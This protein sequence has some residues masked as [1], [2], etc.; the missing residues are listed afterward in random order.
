MLFRSRREITAS[1]GL[2]DQVGIMVT[3]TDRGGAVTYH[4][5][6]QLVAYPILHLDQHG[7]DIH[8]LL[9]KYEEVVMAVLSRYGIPGERIK[10]YPGVWV[11]NKKICALGIGI[12]R[13]V[14]Y[15]GFALNVNTNLDHYNYIIPC[16]IAH[17]GVTSM[18]QVLGHPV[19][20][21]GVRRAVAE[22]LGQIFNLEMLWGEREKYSANKSYSDYGNEEKEVY[23]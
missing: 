7:R 8:K 22:E 5:P 1:P 12:T 17:L 14:S 15:H 16:G 20:E 19:A 13:W 2:L 10:E 4:G 21:T 3:E 23:P 9:H 6:G 18:R 11:K